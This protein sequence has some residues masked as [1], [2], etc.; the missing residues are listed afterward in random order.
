MPLTS[1]I[2]L[3]FIIS[4][5]ILYIILYYNYINKRV[6]N[7]FVSLAKFSILV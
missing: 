3:L 4:P 7:C 5:T 1:L 6:N 2:L